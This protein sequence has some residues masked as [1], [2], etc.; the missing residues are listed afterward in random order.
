LYQACRNL[1]ASYIP[2]R[3][4]TTDISNGQTTLLNVVK[5]LGEYL[6]AEEDDLRT[7]G[8]VKSY[9][10]TNVLVFT[11]NTGV[12]FLSLVVGRCAPENLNRQSGAN[13]SIMSTPMMSC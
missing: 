10:D 6:T 11:F 7:K 3:N 1:D 4:P 8:I 2:L 9:L 12:E 13:H 5:A